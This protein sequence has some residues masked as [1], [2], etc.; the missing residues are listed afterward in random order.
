MISCR[1]SNKKINLF[2]IKLLAVTSNGCATFSDPGMCG[3][4]CKL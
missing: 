4:Y 1:L 2:E 3:K